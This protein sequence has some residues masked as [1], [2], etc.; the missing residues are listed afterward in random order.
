[1]GK[2]I[3]FSLSH[4]SKK[5]NGRNN[6]YIYKAN[7][8]SLI[9]KDAYFYN[10]RYQSSIITKCNFNY[11]HLTGVDFCNS[12]IKNSCFKKAILKDVCFINCNLSGTD[13]S[14]AYFDNVVFVCT[15]VDKIKN[16]RLDSNVKD[17][18]KYPKLIIEDGIKDELL[19]LANSNNILIPHVLHV[20][21]QK[22]NNWSLQILY[23]IYG[24]E[25]INKLMYIKCNEQKNYYTIFSYGKFIQEALKKDKKMI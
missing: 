11:T 22:L 4:Y 18:R 15:N 3:F 24:E 14:E 20:D 8:H 12:N 21:K 25:G 13:F 23:D 5:L 6:E 1:M 10:V 9:F 16:I 7:M 17:Y 2:R 19:Q